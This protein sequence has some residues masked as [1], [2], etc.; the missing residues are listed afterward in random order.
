MR[1]I[2]SNVFGKSLYIDVYSISIVFE[3]REEI[4]GS[5][6][7]LNNSRYQYISIRIPLY[8]YLEK[9]DACHVTSSCSTYDPRPTRA[10][11]PLRPCHQATASLLSLF[12]YQLSA[13]L[14]LSSILELLLLHLLS[15]CP[16]AYIIESPRFAH[17]SLD[18]TISSLRH[19][20][21]PISRGAQ[22]VNRQGIP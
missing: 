4:N 17:E 19:P 12:R 10:Q 20:I 8:L 11:Y 13:S 16:C 14:L 2:K 21:L 1:Y 15:H 7:I 22:I 3:N 6:K 5:H 9:A 18:P